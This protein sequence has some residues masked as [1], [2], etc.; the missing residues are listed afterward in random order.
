KEA[1]EQI[2]KRGLE[3]D[4]YSVKDRSISYSIKK[5]EISDSS[6][7]EDVGLG[8]RVIKDDGIGFG[9]CVPD[10]EEEGVKRAIELSELPEKIDLSFPSDE[11]QPDVKTND[12]KLREWV[13]DSKGAELAQKM[14]D[15]VFLVADDITPTRG[16]LNISIGERI[17]GN[18]NGL[19][20]KEESS[21]ISGYVTATIERENTSLQARE[22]QVSRRLNIDFGEVGTRAGEKVDSMRETSEVLTGDHPVVISPYALSQ[23]FGFGLM[24][25]INGENVRKGKSVYKSKLGKKVAS[26][27]LSVKDDPIVDWGMGS[28]AFD[29]EGVLSRS[30][31][32]ISE[33]VLKN[34]IYNL[35]DGVKSN[36]ETTANGVRNSFKSPPETVHRNIV[37]EGEEK[38]VDDLMPDKGIYV[39]NVLGAHTSNPVNGYFSVVTNPVWLVEE[40][41]KKGRIDGM[42]ISGNLPEVLNSIELADDYKKCYQNIGSQRLIIETPTARLNDVTLSGRND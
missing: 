23:L 7:Y 24:P 41:E 34:F 33:G 3:G 31:P 27:D 19:L 18:T 32:I 4:V 16:L 21:S 14:I 13:R 17:V 2:K 26:E 37:L 22:L 12:E 1:I 29:D 11:N 15:G 42:M 25:A 5:G 30:T 36:T 35:K 39:D 10:K 20:V 6:E 9:Y 28:G 38:R 8:I 40:R